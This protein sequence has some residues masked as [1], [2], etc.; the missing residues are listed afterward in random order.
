MKTLTLLAMLSLAACYSPNTPDCSFLC[1]P[2]GSCPDQ[3]ECRADGYCHHN[4]SPDA[5]CPFAPL[6]GSTAADASSDGAMPDL[7]AQPD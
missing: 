4:G 5:A 2:A 7:T 3:Y 6:D 1:G